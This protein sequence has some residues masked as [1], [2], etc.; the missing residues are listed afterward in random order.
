[1]SELVY[2]LWLS[3]FGWIGLAAS[4]RGVV[5]IT[6]PRHSLRSAKQ[7]LAE[8]TKRRA[9]RGQNSHLRRARHELER[10]F[11]NDRRADLLSI[12]LDSDQGTPFEKQVWS[13]LRDIPYGQTRTYGELAR[14]LGRPQASRAVGRCNAKNPW[15]IV[16]PC[17]RVIGAD[18]SLKGYTGGLGMK[19]KLLQL[20]GIDVTALCATKLAAALERKGGHADRH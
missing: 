5:A 6:T 18:A 11:R 14:L 8:N 17:H 3:S 7:E 2:T 13:L 12:P 15:A 1:M 19:R 10:Y 4:A 20:E 16:V 9:L